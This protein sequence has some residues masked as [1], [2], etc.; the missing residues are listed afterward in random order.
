MTIAYDGV[1]S[2]SSSTTVI[3]SKNRFDSIEKQMSD[4]LTT[5]NTHNFT[6][7]T[8]LNAKYQ[9]K[10]HIIHI[11]KKMKFISAIVSAVC[12]VN[13]VDA[14]APTSLSS[15]LKST[16][17]N[18]ALNLAVGETAPDFTLQ[19]QNGKSIKRSSI[20]KPLVVY[21]YPADS[22]PGCTKQAQSFNERIASIRKTYGADVI[23]ISGQDVVSKQKFAV[24]EKLTFSI[25]AD[26]NDS[27]RKEFNVPKA[28]LGL[29]PGRVTYVL[30]K[31]GVCQLVYKELAN[32]ESHVIKAEEALETMKASAGA[33]KGGNPFASLFN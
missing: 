32:A 24:D 25:L 28:A 14:F 19:D 10:I 20:K 1:D 6:N 11:Y 8:L 30:D 9:I 26:T 18:S 31:S 7:F 33:S 21:F 16:S 17:S 29:F 2:S 5:D 15:N 3:E 27:V 23:G 12:L 22:T 4:P 13:A